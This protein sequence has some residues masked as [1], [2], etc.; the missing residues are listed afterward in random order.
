MFGQ[1]SGFESC[2][3]RIGGPHYSWICMYLRTHLLAKIYMEPPNHIHMVLSWPVANMLQVAR[4][5]SCLTRCFPAHVEWDEALLSAFS[6]HSV[7]K[8]I[9]ATVFSCFCAFPCWFYCLKL[10]PSIELP[11]CLIFL[12]ARRLWCA[13]WRKHMSDK[14]CSGLSDAAVGHSKSAIYIK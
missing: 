8:S 13:L 6:S 1:C 14:L 4:N 3:H 10:P 2:F 7:N 5:L 9:F 11:C 12:C